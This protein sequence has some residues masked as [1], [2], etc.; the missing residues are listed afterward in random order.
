V[1]DREMADRLEI[2]IAGKGAFGRFKD[3]LSPEELARYYQLSD[4]RKRG[5][6]RAWLAAEGY[7]PTTAAHRA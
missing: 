6:A 7:R 5:R 1:Q 3:V 4:E 2:A